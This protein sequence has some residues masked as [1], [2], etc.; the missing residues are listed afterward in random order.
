MSC[1]LIMPLSQ[2][3][4]YAIASLYTLALHSTQV[5]SG[6]TSI[7]EGVGTDTCAWG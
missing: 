1:I 2:Q 4:K 3:H 7:Y 5:D 6:V